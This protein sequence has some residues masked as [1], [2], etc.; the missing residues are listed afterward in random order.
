MLLNYKKIP[1][2]V[3]WV[4]FPE[5]EAMCKSIGAAPSGKKTDGKPH[6]TVPVIKIEPPTG[7]SDPVVVLSDS[8]NIAQY[9]EQR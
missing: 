7:S 9:I 8:Y 4:N 5:I 2:K 6:Y 3:E 1:Y